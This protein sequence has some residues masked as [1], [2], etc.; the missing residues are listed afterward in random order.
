VFFSLLFL[1]F[2][3]S[4]N[5]NNSENKIKRKMRLPFANSDDQFDFDNFLDLFPF[6]EEN[7]TC[8]LF[9]KKKKVFLFLFLFSLSSLSTHQ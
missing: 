3:E 6:W 1:K 7:F 8:S 9:Q 4:T 2:G 5:K